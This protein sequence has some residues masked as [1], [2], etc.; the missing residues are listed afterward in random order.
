MGMH[1][2]SYLSCCIMKSRVNRVSKYPSHH[3][4]RGIY[5]ICS[6]IFR[7]IHKYQSTLT[8]LKCLV[9]IIVRYLHKFKFYTETVRLRLVMDEFRGERSIL[10]IRVDSF[11][12]RLTWMMS[13]S[14]SS[15]LAADRRRKRWESLSSESSP[16]LI[17]QSSDRMTFNM[18]I[19]V[20]R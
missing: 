19:I 17:L 3:K 15:T 7:V 9:A 8:M 13:F 20:G 1:L 4:S 18:N 14:S 16:F 5:Y 12:A 6:F 10:L 2:L 11:L